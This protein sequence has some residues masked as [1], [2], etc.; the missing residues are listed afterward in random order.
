MLL[1]FSGLGSR[2]F[3]APGSGSRLWALD[4]GL[5]GQMFKESLSCYQ[6]CR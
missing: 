2:V 3:R 4:P 5:G 6:R 1:R